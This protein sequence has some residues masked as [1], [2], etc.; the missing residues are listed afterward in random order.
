[1]VANDKITTSV[2]LHNL[3]NELRNEDIYIIKEALSEKK[4][5][6]TILL[7]VLDLFIWYINRFFPKPSERDAIFLNPTPTLWLQRHFSNIFVDYFTSIYWSFGYAFLISLLIL[8]TLSRGKEAWK[9][10]LPIALVWGLN[11]I[12]QLLFPIVVPI[13]WRDYNKTIPIRYV[14][15]EVLGWT[16]KANGILYAGLP[17][18]H[19]GVASAGLMTVLLSMR[20]TR[21]KKRLK[22]LLWLYV[23]T[24]P[25]YSFCVLY[26][27]EHFVEDIIASL[28]LWPSFIYIGYTIL[29]RNYAPQF[30]ETPT[31]VPFG[32]STPNISE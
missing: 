27:G 12:I 16:D 17:S 14:R 18:G 2:F 30:V 3:W 28:I 13:R 11:I 24:I 9:I 31:K 25:I 22:F 8:V 6:M 26:L 7:V 20:S 5:L 1:M 4:N 21:Y 19:I 10:G 32:Q 29:T 23:I 15:F